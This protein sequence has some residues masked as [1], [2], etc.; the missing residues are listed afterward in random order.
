MIVL[1]SRRISPGGRALIFCYFMPG[2]GKQIVFR[3]GI[4]ILLGS[5]GISIAKKGW[6]TSII[7]NRLLYELLVYPLKIKL[8]A[9]INQTVLLLV[10]FRQMGE[11][12]WNLYVVGA[13]ITL[14]TRYLW[15]GEVGEFFSAKGKGN[16]DT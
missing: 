13:A 7:F 8:I 14:S 3:R 10:I 15:K 1:I 2:F 5:G 9:R 4:D 11:I 16:S 12:W 6:S